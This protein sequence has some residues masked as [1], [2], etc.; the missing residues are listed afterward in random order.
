MKKIF[1]SIKKSFYR[2][3]LKA[4]ITNSFSRFWYCRMG[5]VLPENCHVANDVFIK[6]ECSNIILG[7]NVSIYNGG[8]LIAADKISIG[9]NTGI[10]YK[11]LILT[12]SNPRGPRNKLIRIYPKVIAPVTIGHDS[13]IG[14]RVT[15]LPGINIGNYCVIAAGSV[16]TKDVPDY[17]IVGG[18][19]AK[20]IKKLDPRVFQ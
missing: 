4:P 12:S 11:V 1:N 7:K 19:P 16:V 10:A 8:V 6:G 15:I 3:C 17:T 2:V 18:V 20:I 5:L 9:E 14:A 13:W